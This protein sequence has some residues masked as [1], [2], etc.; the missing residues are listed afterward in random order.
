MNPGIWCQFESVFFGARWLKSS[1][2]IELCLALN[3][4]QAV[5]FNGQPLVSGQL[6]V[7]FCT[8]LIPPLHCV[9]SGLHVCKSRV[10][11][12]VGHC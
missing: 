4:L 9:S 11:S 12:V 1:D 7:P 10:L 8:A 6:S 3:N 5:L 2:K